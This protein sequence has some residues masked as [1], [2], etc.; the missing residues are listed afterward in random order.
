MKTKR[1]TR[2]LR[3][4]RVTRGSRA[5]DP[6]APRCGLCGSTT[7][8][9]TRTECCGN[10]ICDDEDQYVLFSYARN[11]C[12]RNHDRY[13]LCSYH[14]NEGH[15]GRWQDCQKCREGFEAEMYVYFG[16]NEYNFETLENPPDYEPTHCVNCGRVIALGTDGY[17]MDAD[18]YW[19]WQCSQEKMQRDLAADKQPSRSRARTARPRRRVKRS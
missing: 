15:E 3:L 1:A 5:A 7:K 17:S 8:P 18:G 11:S 13:T 19:C 10:W 14:Y 6:D 4:P 12:H 16:T 9:L 2:T